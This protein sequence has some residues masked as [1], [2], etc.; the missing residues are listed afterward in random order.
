MPM[1]QPLDRIRYA[2]KE[3]HRFQ[4][5]VEDWKSAHDELAND[6]WVW[7]DLIARANSLFQRIIQLDAYVREA[8]LAGQIDFDPETEEKVTNLLKD[9][10]EIS[11]ELV[12][13]A[14]RLKT[15]YGAVEGLTELQDK[16]GQA[17]AILTPDPVFFGTDELA[18]LRDEAIEDHRSGQTEPLLENGPCH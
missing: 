10:L 14:E 4:H 18:K 2:A 6:C 16:I 11:L 3:V 8:V 9:W 17:K 1:T 12:P 13:I 5:D 15:E 7:E